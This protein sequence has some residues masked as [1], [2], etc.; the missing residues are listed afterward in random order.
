MAATHSQFLGVAS[1]HCPRHLFNSTEY[2]LYLWFG[3][4]I[5][6]GILYSLHLAARAGTFRPAA[7]KIYYL[8]IWF[9]IL[10]KK[11]G[12]KQNKKTLLG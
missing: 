2:G 5:S 3:E 1:E 12:E 7:R 11:N 9:I 4:S 6:T 8:L 10:E